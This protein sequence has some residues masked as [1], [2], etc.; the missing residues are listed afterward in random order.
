MALEIHGASKTLACRELGIS[1]NSL[2][3]PTVRTSSDAVLRRWLRLFAR[4]HPRWGWRKA[5]WALRHKDVVIN[6]KKVRRLWREEGLCRKRKS[7]KQRCQKPQVQVTALFPNHVWA[8]DFQ[9]DQTTNG[10]LLK[11][12]NIVDEFTR[13]SLVS[14]VARSI[15]NDDVRNVLADLIR[16]RNAQP[17]FLRSDNGAEFAAREL[18]EWLKDSG[19]TNAF[20]QPA[21]PWQNGKAE[22]YNGIFRD[23]LLNMELFESVEHAQHLTNVWKHTYNHFRPHGSLRGATPAAFAATHINPPCL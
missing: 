11:W 19:V 6:H 15:T 22:S 12:L 8:L 3:P 13:E 17:V 14:V 4:K 21:S 7:R 23:E 5:F 18:V 20:I 1:R 2:V 16:A 10:R 9:F